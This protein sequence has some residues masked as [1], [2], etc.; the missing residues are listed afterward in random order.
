MDFTVYETFLENL[1]SIVRGIGNLI[2]EAESHKNL[3]LVWSPLQPDFVAVGRLKSVKVELEKANRNSILP[4]ILQFIDEDNFV[5][6]LT[7][8]VDD[9]YEG[10]KPC[11][12]V[13]VGY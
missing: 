3:P 11:F 5:V 9:E 13:S 2:Y 7:Y 4:F 10:K 1:A 12:H 6:E 8:L